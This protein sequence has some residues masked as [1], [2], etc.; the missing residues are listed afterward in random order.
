MTET[1]KMELPLKWGWLLAGVTLGVRRSGHDAAGSS[2]SA[3]GGAEAN[4]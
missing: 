4:P 2:S 1:E 3:A